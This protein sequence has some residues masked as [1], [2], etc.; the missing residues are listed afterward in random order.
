M[1]LLRI[2]ALVVAIATVGSVLG[3]AA[4][5]SASNAGNDDAAT[6]ARLRNATAK[7]HDADKAP[8]GG[9]VNLDVCVDHMG[10]HFGRIELP[11]ANPPFDGNVDPL[12]PEALVYADDGTGHLKLVAVEWI[13]TQPQHV[14]GAHDLHFNSHFQLW[15]LHA[16]IWSPNPDGMFADMNPLV[17]TCP[18]QP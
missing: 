12:N 6:L 1:R 7:Y 4:V 3:V 2:A 16:W 15:I 13:A 17:G 10:Q 14:F 18:P 11:Q 8:D 9:R 5:A